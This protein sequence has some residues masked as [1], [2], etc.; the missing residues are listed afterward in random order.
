MYILQLIIKKPPQCQSAY[1]N[2]PRVMHV[3]KTN[4]L[5]QLARQVYV[6]NRQTH[7]HKKYMTYIAHVYTNTHTYYSSYMTLI[8][9]HEMHG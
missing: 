5:S 8:G 4:P 2:S 3:L 6:T 1:L 7:T 9:V